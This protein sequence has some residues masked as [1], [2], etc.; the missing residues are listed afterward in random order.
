MSL[1]GVTHYI[2]PRD[3]SPV[4]WARLGWKTSNFVP[5]RESRLRAVLIGV[6]SNDVWKCARKNQRGI[7]YKLPKFVSY[8]CRIFQAL[9]VGPVS[10]PYNHLSLMHCTQMIDMDKDAWFTIQTRKFGWKVA[11]IAK[12]WCLTEVCLKSKHFLVINAR[13]FDSFNL[14]TW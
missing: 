13:H 3:S 1:V 9:S 12:N 2:R 6:G 4:S 14:G 10:F 8:R 7:P 11:K 5:Q